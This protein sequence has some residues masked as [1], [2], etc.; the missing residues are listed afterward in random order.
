MSCDYS[1]VGINRSETFVPLDEGTCDLIDSSSVI[2]ERCSCSV[3]IEDPSM[4]M[5]SYYFVFPLCVGTAGE[6]SVNVC[7]PCCLLSVT[8][9]LSLWAAVHSCT[10]LFHLHTS[11]DREHELLCRET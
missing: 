8:G 11:A 6:R 2:H 5:F 10:L 4:I 7:G 1:I 3:G 9:C